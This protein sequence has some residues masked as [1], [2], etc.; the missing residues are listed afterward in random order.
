MASLTKLISLSEASIGFDPRVRAEKS[1]V[2][3]FKI[4][5]RSESLKFRYF[6]LAAVPEAKRSSSF[7]ILFLKKYGAGSSSRTFGMQSKV[8]SAITV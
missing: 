1:T 4:F 2:K 7:C 8:N 6:Y 3:N 5:E